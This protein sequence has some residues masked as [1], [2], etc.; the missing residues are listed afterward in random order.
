MLKYLV[1]LTFDLMP[2]GLI[3]GMLLAYIKF[4]FP[5]LGSRILYAACCA[6]VAAAARKLAELSGMNET[7]CK[8][9]AIA[10][11]LHDVGKLRVP[12][13][14]LEKPGKLTDEEFNIIKEH[15]YYTRWILKDVDG[16]EKIA[17]WAAFHHEKLNGK[18]YPFHLTGE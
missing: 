18:G 5:R 12:N 13:S 6:G 10:G 4:N 16:F 8:K 7:D 11:Y 14:I 3:I 1:Q 9:M 17:N 15:T 2:A